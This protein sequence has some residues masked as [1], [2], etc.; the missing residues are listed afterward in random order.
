MNRFININIFNLL[1]G[2]TRTIPHLCTRK[3]E[4]I[5][6]FNNI[7]FKQIKD[8][9][10]YYISKCG[11]IL[12][13]KNWHGNNFKIL[14]TSLTWKGYEMLVFCMNNKKYTQRVT[15]LLAKTWI[16]NPENKKT[17]NHIN[18]IKTDN[19]VENLEW[20]T[21]SENS[22]HAWKLGLQKLDE[23]HFKKGCKH[24]WR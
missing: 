7:K 14:K 5:I 6:L 18:G 9:P 19:R 11:K 15:R 12:S 16:P 10:D 24:I 22:K 17:I 8:F 4:E 2:G 20:C 23:H 1:M 13:T 3:M 21:Q